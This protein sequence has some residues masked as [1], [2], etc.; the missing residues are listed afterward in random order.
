M[1]N[2]WK[3]AKTSYLAARVM[4]IWVSQALP[5]T[6]QNQIMYH[7]VPQGGVYGSSH[8]EIM[9]LLSELLNT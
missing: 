4:I 9:H 7:N 6:L 3:N 5:S 1:T 2:E 8:K